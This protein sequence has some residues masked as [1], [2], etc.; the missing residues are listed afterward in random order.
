MRHAPI[1]PAA[2]TAPNHNARLALLS[3]LV[4]SNQR[5][6]KLIAHQVFALLERANRSQPAILATPLATEL[7]ATDLIALKQPALLLAQTLNPLT[8][9]HLTVLSEFAMVPHA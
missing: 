9:Q 5:A 7:V 2:L 4:K 6:R 1:F 3:Q 8:V